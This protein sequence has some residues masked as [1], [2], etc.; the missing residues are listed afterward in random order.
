MSETDDRDMNKLAHQISHWA[1]ELVATVGPQYDDRQLY[2]QDIPRLF[3]ACMVL[4]LVVLKN[5][6]DATPLEMKTIVDACMD[7]IKGN[8]F[9]NKLSKEKP[10]TEPDGLAFRGQTMGNA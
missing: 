10:A 6:S 5:T 8:L 9:A 7:D 2:A 3:A 1:E 4:S